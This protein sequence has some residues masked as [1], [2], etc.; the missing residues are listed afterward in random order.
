MLGEEPTHFVER[1]RH[2][3]N[4][5]FGGAQRCAEDGFGDVTSLAVDRWVEARIGVGVVDDDAAAGLECRADDA[6][7]AEKTNFSAT[8]ALRH[9]RIKFAGTGVVEEEAA[10]VAVERPRGHFDQFFQDLIERFRPRYP[11]GN[12]QEN[13]D[14]LEPLVLAANARLNLRLGH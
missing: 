12:I 6:I 13:V 1:L 8:D 4:V 10:A 5:A 2:T 9:A 14:I 7:V 11:P 3:Y